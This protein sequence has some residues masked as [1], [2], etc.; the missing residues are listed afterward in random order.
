[1]HRF[2][3]KF[4]HGLPPDLPRRYDPRSLT[5]TSKGGRRGLARPW[6]GEATQQKPTTWAGLSAPGHYERRRWSARNQVEEVLA[7]PLENPIQ[8]QHAESLERHPADNDALV[9]EETKSVCR[10]FDAVFPEV[11]GAQVGL[12]LLLGPHAAVGCGEGLRISCRKLA[13]HPQTRRLREIP[14]RRPNVFRGHVSTFV[15]ADRWRKADSEATG[16]REAASRTKGM[17]YA[18]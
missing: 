1:M 10:C 2:G 3:N 12:F 5:R 14:E 15:V 4:A 16:R 9:C 11:L 13:W 17:A 6:R 7:C 18:R 8:T